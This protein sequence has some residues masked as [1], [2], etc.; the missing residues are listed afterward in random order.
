[1]E[2]FMII[3][4]NFEFKDNDVKVYI[5]SNNFGDQLIEYFVFKDGEFLSFTNEIYQ[6]N[7]H[8]S[9]DQM[10]YRAKNYLSI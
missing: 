8:I 4:D 5:K 3:G 2:V 1:M 7:E 6:E 10:T 9:I